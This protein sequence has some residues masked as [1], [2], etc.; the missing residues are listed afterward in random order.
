MLA[1]KINARVSVLFF[2]LIILHTDEIDA[3]IG[4]RV[5]VEEILS[6]RATPRGMVEYLVRWEGYP[7]QFDTWEPPEN[8]GEDGDELIA[9]YMASLDPVRGK[10]EVIE[11][12]RSSI[13]LGAD[14]SLESAGQAQ[15]FESAPP[16]KRS[17][18]FERPP[19]LIK[20]DIARKET[21]SSHSNKP[22]VSEKPVHVPASRVVIPISSPSVPAA[23]AAASPVKKAVALSSED[24]DDD[25]EDGDDDDDDDKDEDDDG[26]DDDDDHG[27]L[28]DDDMQ[29][30]KMGSK[31]GK[32]ESVV[33]TKDTI[34]TDAL[35]PVAKEEQEEQEEREE[36][37]E[38]KGGGYEAQQVRDGI[39]TVP[40][41]AHIEEAPR[42][43]KEEEEEEDSSD[44]DVVVSFDLDDEAE[45]DEG[46]ASINSNKGEK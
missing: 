26:Y 16:I 14:G 18:N 17:K 19:E 43:E 4:L 15:R 8:L 30:K 46:N 36:L 25:D 31:V 2:L 40:A 10:K 33:A 27:D 23:A 34:R 1:V 29:R 21:P 39:E 7:P 3:A 9:Q 28:D 20:Y 24:D 45:S 37:E 6:R 35:V 42:G 22:A 12:K 5:D 44:S 11:R 38:R 13:D 41:G 32:E